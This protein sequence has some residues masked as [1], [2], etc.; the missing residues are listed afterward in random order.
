MSNG[1]LSPK[2]VLE[3]D[4]SV[5]LFAEY[6][7][8]AVVPGVL[9]DRVQ[10]HLTRWAGH[11]AWP[12]SAR[13]RREPF[14]RHSDHDPEGQPTHGRLQATHRGRSR[15]DFRYM[16]SWAFA[17]PENRLLT[18]RKFHHNA[19]Q[20][21][22][23]AAPCAFQGGLREITRVLYSIGCGITTHGHFHLESE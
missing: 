1:S 5:D 21:I 17:G 7:G 10:Q 15:W 11:R 6:I 4:C 9:P 13:P 19:A 2:I 12:A 22:Y 3:A 16:R 23:F 18:P 8:M 14:A 20:G